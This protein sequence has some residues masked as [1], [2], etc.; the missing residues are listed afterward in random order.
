M[1][2]SLRPRPRAVDLRIVI[3]LLVAAVLVTSLVSQGWAT[4][5]SGGDAVNQ[6]AVELERCVA[7]WLRAP[8]APPAPVRGG[9]GGVTPLCVLRALCGP[10]ACQLGHWRGSVYTRVWCCVVTAR[11]PAPL[12]PPHPPLPPHLPSPAASF[13]ISSPRR[14]A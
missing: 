3:V 1:D 5:G 13:V 4:F 12:T 11:P 8:A 14:C 2:P 9:T 10:L 6:V 7:R